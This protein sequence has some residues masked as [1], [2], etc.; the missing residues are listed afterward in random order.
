MQITKSVTVQCIPTWKNLASCNTKLE[1]SHFRARFTV[2]EEFPGACFNFFLFE[3][4]FAFV[5]LVENSLKSVL[6][7]V[8]VAAAAARFALLS[9]PLWLLR[10]R[11]ELEELELLLETC[12]LSPSAALVA[13]EVLSDSRARMHAPSPAH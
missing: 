2:H 13:A 1:N 10:L 9:M 12:V 4:N 11:F 5:L 7:E 6:R 3:R 8:D